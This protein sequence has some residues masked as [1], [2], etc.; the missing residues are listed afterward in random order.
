MLFEISASLFSREFHQI[1]LW[2]YF[3]IVQYFLFAALNVAAVQYLG[4]IANVLCNSVKNH[5][6]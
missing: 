5:W 1:L 4:S 2:Y 3:A 6:L